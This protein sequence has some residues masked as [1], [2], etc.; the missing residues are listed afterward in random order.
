MR[1]SKDSHGIPMTSLQSGKGYQIKPDIYYYTNQ[2]VNV[3]F[4]G[5]PGKSGWTLV[6]AGMPNSGGEIIEVAETRF[7][8]DSVPDAIVLTHGHFDHVG[9][10][11]HLLDHWKNVPVYA[12][13]LEFP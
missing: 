3:I 12:H 10:I 1:Q 7:G 8:K 2:I 6:D 5:Q 4:I 13:P 11:V 9:S